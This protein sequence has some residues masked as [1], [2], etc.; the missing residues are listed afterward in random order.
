[1][2]ARRGRYRR[3][4]LDL[5]RA[6]THEACAALGLDPVLDPSNADPRYT[7]ARVRSALA[8]LED[9]LGPGLPAALAR[10]AALLAEDAAALEL[11]AAELLAAARGAAGPWVG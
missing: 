11:A 8:V 7:R 2:P 5:P 9:A 6:V 10:T 1:M 4:L 3:P